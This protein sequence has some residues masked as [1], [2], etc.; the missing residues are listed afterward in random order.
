MKKALYCTALILFIIVLFANKVHGSDS[1]LDVNSDGNYIEGS[2][3]NSGDGDG[4]QKIDQI[5]RYHLSGAGKVN[6]HFIS[7]IWDSITVTVI[8]SDENIL[9]EKSI[10]DSSSPIDIRLYQN[11]GDYYIYISYYHS[12]RSVGD[13]KFKIEYFPTEASLDYITLG[14]TYKGIITD[15]ENAFTDPHQAEL[16]LETEGKFNVSLETDSIVECKFK[17]EDEDSVQTIRAYAR[18]PFTGKMTLP[19]GK[20]IVE[21]SG[22]SGVYELTIARKGIFYSNDNQSKDKVSFVDKLLSSSTFIGAVIAGVL[23]LVG[24]IIGNILNSNNKQSKEE[25]SLIDKIFSP[26]TFIG[27]LIVSVLGGVVVGIILHL[28]NIK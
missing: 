16:W 14:K 26:S 2:I 1:V 15:S 27:A 18:K 22:V 25:V 3:Y 20:I 6:I 17:N 4:K 13:Y 9:E 8:D 19:K 23:L 7:H 24:I 12:R 10:S 21:F 11:E 28:L 5:Y